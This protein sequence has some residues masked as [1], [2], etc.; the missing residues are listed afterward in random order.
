MLFILFP[1]YQVHLPEVKSMLD[2]D[3][4][5]MKQLKKRKE[6]MFRRKRGSKKP[7]IKV[8]TCWNKIVASH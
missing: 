4:A 5:Q 7:W 1:V 2:F 3:D 8:R 6:I